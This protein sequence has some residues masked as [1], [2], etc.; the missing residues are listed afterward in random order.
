[1]NTY[2]LIQ[3][4]QLLTR[5]LKPSFILILL[6]LILAM[7]LMMSLSL[8]LSLRRLPRSL[9]LRNHHTRL[10]SLRRRIRPNNPLVRYDLERPSFRL[11]ARVFG[12]GYDD[13]RSV[14]GADAFFWYY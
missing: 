6:V 10:P 8:S 4:P 9:R 7:I 14:E 5:Q 11:G 12:G 13:E 1:M 2:N 3:L